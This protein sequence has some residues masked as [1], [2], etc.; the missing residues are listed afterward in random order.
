MK[1]LN[2]AGVP[3]NDLITW[4]SILK[5]QDMDPTELR[6]GIEKM[7]DIKSIITSKS[8]EVRNLENKID[9]LTKIHNQLESQLTSLTSNTVKE[10]EYN[11]GRF[12][13]ILDDFDEQF[14]SEETGFNAHSKGY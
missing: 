11:L 14:L 13:K 9:Q 10:V 12:K 2:N 8:G 5:E 3:N 4:N 7:G 1:T 6:R